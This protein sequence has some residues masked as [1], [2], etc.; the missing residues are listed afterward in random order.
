KYMHVL[1]ADGVRELLFRIPALLLGNIALA[2]VLALLVGW[3]FIR[4]V[5][6]LIQGIHDLAK[7][8][9]VH[10]APKGVFR[11]L[12]RSINQASLLL[13]A[14]NKALKERERPVPTGLPAS[15]TMSGRPSPWCWAMPASWR[16]MKRC[17]GRSGKRPG[18]SAG[19]VKNCATSSMI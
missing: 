9:I 7:E 18:S 3:R 19:R 14:K 11:D 16:K 6:P 5:R 8:R 17:L 2:L 1:P 15:P 10:V 4:S 13:Q 12:A